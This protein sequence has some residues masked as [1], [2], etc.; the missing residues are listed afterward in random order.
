MN[1]R[2]TVKRSD[3]TK[4]CQELQLDLLDEE[5]RDDVEFYEQAGVSFRAEDDADVLTIEL[6]SST[7]L[8]AFGTS[9]RGKRPTVAIE[10][11]EGGLY[12]AGTFK[13]FLKSDGSVYLG[14]KDA[15]DFVALASKVMSELATIRTWANSHIHTSAAP[16]SPTSTTSVAGTP[17]AAA[18]SV[19]ATKVKAV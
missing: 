16:G 9:G 11:G 4:G 2:G 15:T 8:A 5:T 17:L 14:D 3:V 1:V 18:N 19:A 10:K 6:G 13:V 12:Y 7:N